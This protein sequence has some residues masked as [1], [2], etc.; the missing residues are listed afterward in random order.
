MNNNKHTP[1]IY[2]HA[3]DYG[4][5]PCQSERILEC[6]TSGNLNSISIIPNVSDLEQCF[7]IL[8]NHPNSASI[9]RVLH[10]NFV[11]G[12]PVSDAMDVYLLVDKNGFFNISFFKL[13]IWNYCLLGAKR[14]ALKQQ[15]L[16]EINNQFKRLT[17]DEDFHITAIDS[18]QHYHMI[19]MVM[20]ALLEVV[21]GNPQITEIRIPVD[22]IAPWLVSP[23]VWSSTPIINLIKWMLLSVL[24]INSRKKLKRHN[25]DSP[26]FLGIPFTC[27][28][29]KCVVSTLLP[30]YLKIAS[31]K[32]KDLEIMLHP[33]YLDSRSELLDCRSDMLAAFYLSPDRK[34][35]EACFYK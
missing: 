20:D 18:H 24:S 3:D 1:H 34:D 15:L 2:Y 6:S 30:K 23:S 29:K 28:M 13:L 27:A 32:N 9:R 19:P 25:I 8:N 33:G 11:E 21:D 5:T 16:L 35:E 31:N 10:I 12:R 26:V 17:S 4:I 7:T 14:R 22:P